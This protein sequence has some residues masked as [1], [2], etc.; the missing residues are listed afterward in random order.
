MCQ[1]VGTNQKAVICS[2]PISHIQQIKDQ[3][4]SKWAKTYERQILR[5]DINNKA[6]KHDDILCLN[7]YPENNNKYFIDIASFLY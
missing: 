3:L 2:S 4:H 1:G 7:G 6:P 5:R